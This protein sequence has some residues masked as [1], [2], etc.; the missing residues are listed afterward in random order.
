[1]ISDTSLQIILFLPNLISLELHR[2]KITGERL[3]NAGI[4]TQIE[5]LK[6]VACPLSDLGLKT[7]LDICGR[8][9]KCLDVSK[10]NISGEAEFSEN[11]VL[12][13]KLEQLNCH[14]C[15]NLSDVGLLQL[16][17]LCQ[18]SIKT[19]DIGRTSVSGQGLVELQSLPSIKELNCHSCLKLSEL[20]FEQLMKICGK[21]LSVL[22]LR[23]TNI[24]GESLIK[25]DR[26]S[27][28][29]LDCSY[30]TQL[31]DLGRVYSPKNLGNGGGE[32]QETSVIE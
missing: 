1:M 17:K 2:T 8:Q 26:L 24:S 19:L 20:G 15:V 23:G 12:L 6:L 9:L 13:P 25:V 22:I 30:C 32:V 3:K 31:S 7:I 11:R 21:T 29:E 10:T 27:L 4:F 18:N 5:T 14:G 28:V 16:L